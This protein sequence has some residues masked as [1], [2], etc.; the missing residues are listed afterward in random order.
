MLSS[1]HP[2]NVQ[3]MKVKVLRQFRDKHD[4]VTRYEVGTEHEFESERASNLIERGLA[5]AVEETPAPTTEKDGGVAGQKDS[6]VET[7]EPATVEQKAEEPA[8]TEAQAKAK[9]KA[10]SPEK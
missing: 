5:E 10:K 1:G 7:T 8:K 6:E 3:K 4:H 2:V 9:S